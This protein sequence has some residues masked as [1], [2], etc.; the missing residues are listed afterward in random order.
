MVGANALLDFIVHIGV[1]K[2]LTSQDTAAAVA[3]S[4]TTARVDT[5][6]SRRQVVV[7]NAVLAVAQLADGA[8]STT[9]SSEVE[10]A[11]VTAANEGVGAGSESRESD[12]GLHHG[13]RKRIEPI[14][15]KRGSGRGKGPLDWDIGACC[16]EWSR[17]TKTGGSD[18]SL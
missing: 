11:A 1:S 2:K 12:E 14:Q 7:T 4:N 16:L 3:V 17:G 18:A 8:R 5:V 15:R 10:A 6:L 9:G 13:K